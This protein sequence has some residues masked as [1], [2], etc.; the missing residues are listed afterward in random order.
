[1][2]SKPSKEANSKTK[3][4]RLQNNLKASFQTIKANT[5][6]RRAKPKTKMPNAQCRNAKLE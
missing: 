3:E 4:R 6:I 5:K 1:V 2:K